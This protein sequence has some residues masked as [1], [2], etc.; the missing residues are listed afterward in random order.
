M[1]TPFGLSRVELG[2]GQVSLKC[3]MPGGHRGNP[4]CMIKHA[5]GR[6]WSLEREA[7]CRAGARALGAQV[8]ER[9]DR[10]G[11]VIPRNLALV[12]AVVKPTGYLSLI[13]ATMNS[14]R[15]RVQVG[16]P[17]WSSTTDMVSR[18]LARRRVALMKLGP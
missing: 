12:G 10:A 3:V 4:S 9:E 5:I 7:C 1:R 18:S 17:L 2:D 8:G 6:P 15:S 16:W 11:Q 13:S 14:Q